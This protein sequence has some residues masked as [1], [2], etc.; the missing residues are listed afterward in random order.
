MLAKSQSN[1]RRFIYLLSAPIQHPSNTPKMSQPWFPTISPGS[2][3]PYGRRWTR[4]GMSTSTVPHPSGWFC[5][6]SIASMTAVDGVSRLV[7][8]TPFGYSWAT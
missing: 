8:G 3:L 6:A 7:P 5:I 1:F 2:R 4:W